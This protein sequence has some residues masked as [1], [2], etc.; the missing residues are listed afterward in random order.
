MARP[1]ARAAS[2][3][4]FSNADWHT[5]SSAEKRDYRNA[6]RNADRRVHNFTKRS[7]DK[8]KGQYRPDDWTTVEWE[9]YMEEMGLQ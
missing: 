1:I 7:A 9:I 3:L 5:L 2:V 4:G 6:V 8:R